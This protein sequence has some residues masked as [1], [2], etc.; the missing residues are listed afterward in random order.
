MLD[1]SGDSTEYI[2]ENAA[3]QVVIWKK[4][5]SSTPNRKGPSDIYLTTVAM[6]TAESKADTE[7]G[8]ISGLCCLKQRTPKRNLLDQKSFSEPRASRG[9]GISDNDSAVQA[10]SNSNEVELPSSPRLS[11]KGILSKSL[12]FG[13]TL[14]KTS[15]EISS[16]ASSRLETRSSVSGILRN[17]DNNV[18]KQ[19]QCDWTAQEKKGLEVSIKM[20]AAHL[21]INPPKTFNVQVKIIQ[22]NAPYG[23]LIV[24]Q[25][26]EC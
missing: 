4:I 5:R 24:L 26:T 1:C 21:N 22:L 17:S 11:R 15:F 6:G 7:D 16:T 3:S 19:K 10:R 9:F 20:A 12:S 2:S 14:N 13:N 25:N 8:G 23:F 18:T